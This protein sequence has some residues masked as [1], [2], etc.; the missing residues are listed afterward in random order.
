MD[1]YALSQ[2]RFR[3]SHG[4]WGQFLGFVTR[5]QA[6]RAF[7]KLQNMSDYQLKDIGLSRAEVERL[8]SLPLSIDPT[9]EAEQFRLRRSR[10]DE[11]AN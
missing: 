7:R 8:S 3:Q 5:W 2:A 4:L 9:W 1:D 10:R 11:P 6:R